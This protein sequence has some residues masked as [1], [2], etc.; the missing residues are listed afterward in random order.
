MSFHIYQINAEARKNAAKKQ[1]QHEHVQVVIQICFPTYRSKY[2][3][4]F[5]PIAL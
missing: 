2:V 3:Y 5:V 4:V 1:E